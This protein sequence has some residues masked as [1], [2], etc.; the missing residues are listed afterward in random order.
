MRLKTNP[1]LIFIY[2]RPEG[3][4]NIKNIFILKQKSSQILRAFFIIKYFLII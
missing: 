2:P 1:S 4:G 3:R